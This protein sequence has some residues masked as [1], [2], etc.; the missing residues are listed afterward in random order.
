MQ[1]HSRAYAA[2]LAYLYGRTDWER[3]VMD[4]TMRERLLLERPAALLARLEHPERRY[5][6]ILIAG[7]KGK[8]STG[9]MLA[10]I[11]RATGYRTGFYSQPHLHSYRERLRVDGVPITPGHL[12]DGVSRLEPHVAALERE[13]PELGECTTYEVAT[14]LALEHFARAGVAAAVLE[15]GLGGR[16]DATNV[17]AA[18]LSIV[19]S[20]SFDHTA[21]LGSTL[22]QIATEKAGIIKTGRP[23]FSAPQ[24]PEVLPVLERVADERHAL[25]FVGMR[26]WRWTGSHDGLAVE[27]AGTTWPQ[28]WRS[29]GIHVPLLGAHQLENAA[30]A[31]AAAHA[32]NS[33][34]AGASLSVPEAAIRAGVAGTRWPARVEVFHP[35]ARGGWDDRRPIPSANLGQAL[36]Q[37]QDRL[38]DERSFSRLGAGANSAE[39][40]GPLVVVDGA[41]N[42]DSAEKLAAALRRHFRFE[43]LLLV[44]GA[45]AD[46]DLGTIVAPLAPLAARAWAVASSHPR[47]RPAAEVA[48]ALAAAGFQATPAA[49]TRAAIEEALASAAERD[50]VC[51]TGS[52]FVAAEAREALGAVGPEEVDPPVPIG[53]N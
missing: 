32:L 6:T 8:G 52:L 28:P 10:S 50:L 13:R 29:D 34:L 4:E 43:R 48:Q 37:A 45:G 44:L 25:L 14:A 20:I 41:H 53:V 7:T 26:A 42:G 47:S 9:A 12:A 27:S 19:T 24:R 22:P 46:K 1:P 38:S 2:A 31:V 5:R 18:D 40:A 36:R 11:L 16:L 21:V 49:S 33:G 23:V 51:V 30:T 39:S 15:V 17:V 3:R 35:G